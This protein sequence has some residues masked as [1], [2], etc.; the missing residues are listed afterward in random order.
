M[1]TGLEFGLSIILGAFVVLGLVALR[2]PGLGPMP[3]WIAGWIAAGASGVLILAAPDFPRL[4]FL[5]FPLGTLFPWLLLAG[6]LVF[7]GRRVPGWMLP[8]ALAYGLARS[9]LA[10]EGRADVAYALALAVEPCVALAAGW[11]AHRAVSHPGA[12]LGL[13]LLGP[14]FVPVT[15]AGAT[16]RVQ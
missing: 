7:A 4:Q 3:F 14:S 15:A 5:T 8:G 6:A 12:A 2:R 13:R 9:V 1:P 11:V 16:T 10:A